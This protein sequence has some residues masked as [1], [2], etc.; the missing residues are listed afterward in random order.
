[1]SA[2][3]VVTIT[4]DLD[5]KT[6]SK[7][8][9]MCIREKVSV[10]I[11]GASAA[12]VTGIVLRVIEPCGFTEMAKCDS[13]TPSGATFVGTLDLS[14]DD[15]AGEFSDDTADKTRVFMIQVWN[16]VDEDLI[17]NDR[18]LI[19]NNPLTTAIQAE[20]LTAP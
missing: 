7:S 11:S 5:K 4:V 9:V 3:S 14:G 16:T 6:V 17:I 10:V 20:T 19:M 8:G 2:T 12:D 1:M 18:I 15:L 13:F